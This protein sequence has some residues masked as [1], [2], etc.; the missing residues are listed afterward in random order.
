MTMKFLRYFSLAALAALLS[1]SAFA[2]T[3]WIDVRSAVEHKIDRIDGDPRISHSK[4]ASKIS[5]LVPDKST[6]I[7]LY[8]RSGRRSGIAMDALQAAGYKNVTNAGGIDDA[9]KARSLSD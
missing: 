9:R 4:I 1:F 7:R 2:D 6:D 5:E 3:V 8:C